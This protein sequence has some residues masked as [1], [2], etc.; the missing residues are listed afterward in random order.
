M[1]CGQV[2]CAVF[3]DVCWKWAV[4]GSAKWMLGHHCNVPRATQTN[5]VCAEQGLESERW[6]CKVTL[7]KCWWESLSR[8][9]AYC[10]GVCRNWTVLMFLNCSGEPWG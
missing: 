4:A 8:S 2:D 9:S 3:W 6:A 7:E 10:W 1:V 5:L